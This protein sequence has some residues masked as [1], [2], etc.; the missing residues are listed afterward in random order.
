MK[1]SM[2]KRV[3]KNNT[4]INI[5]GEQLRGSSEFHDKN[6]NKQ[7]DTEIKCTE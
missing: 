5:G 4:S 7:N 3:V 2:H 6:S 1:N